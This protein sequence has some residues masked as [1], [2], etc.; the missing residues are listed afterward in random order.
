MSQRDA[1]FIHDKALDQGG[2]P[3]FCP[4]NTGRP[5]RTRQ[6]V[7]QM[8]LLEGEG[9][10]VAP[11][12]PLERAEIER[13]HVPAYVSAL[14]ES[15][16]PGA[17]ALPEFGLGTVDCPVFEGMYDYVRMAAGGTLTG[18][19]MILSGEA[20]IVFNP[21]GGFHHALPDQASGFCYV[22]DVVIAIRELV[23]AGKRVCSARHSRD[24]LRPRRAPPRGARRACR[25]S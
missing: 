13:F 20:G 1:V 6:I 4:F 8:G 22:N 3:S 15:S 16:R 19:R 7:E 9:R 11:P 21:A 25:S 5:G 12:V 2:Y 14:Q 17:P 23:G 24:S 18:A 10:R